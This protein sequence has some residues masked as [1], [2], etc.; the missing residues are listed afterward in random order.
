MFG[1]ERNKST[2]NH[3]VVLSVA[4]LSVVSYVLYRLVD[5]R[6]GK[7][8]ELIKSNP[9]YYMNPKMER[10]GLMVEQALIEH[11]MKVRRKKLGLPL[12]T[13]GIVEIFDFEKYVDDD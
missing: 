2:N 11:E 8:E 1:P 4:A 7:I 5:Y 9:K 13:S 6:Q 12:R 3:L 10:N